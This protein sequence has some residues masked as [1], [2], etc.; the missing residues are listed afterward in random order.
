MAFALSF[1]DNVRGAAFGAR[2]LAVALKL[3]EPRRV[4]CALAFQ[5]GYVGSAGTQVWP[6]T[7]RL[8]T[9]ATELAAATGD[10]YTIALVEMATGVAHFLCGRYPEVRPHLERARHIFV[11]QCTGVAWEID[12]TQM[13]A[14]QCCIVFGEFREVSRVHP[15]YLREATERGDAYAVAYLCTGVSGIHW[16]ARDEP[17]RARE[18]AREAMKN[19][20]SHGFHLE[21]FYEQNLLGWIELYEGRTDDAERRSRALWPAVKRSLLSRVQMVRILAI[22][23][24]LI[25]SLAVAEGDP[26]CKSTALR[27][28]SADC[29]R[30]AR[31]GSEYASAALFRSCIVSVTGEPSER[32]ALAAR[33]AK[34][35]LTAV[36]C[37]A[38]AIFAQRLLGLAMG[39][40]EGRAVVA[41]AEQW[42]LDQ[43]VRDPARFSRCFARGF[44]RFESPEPATPAS[45]ALSPHPPS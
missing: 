24:R 32:V 12:T 16:L 26:R 14:L 25:G 27:S 2:N 13:L 43:G 20:S 4:A 37:T 21:H 42:L 38:H 5:L 9:R 29:A 28:A 41:S 7:Q 8:I 23:Q 30:L 45:T 35:A 22:E 31:E 17:D 36:G 11:S 1:A 6:Q 34:N 3:G 10:P 33:A 40:D 44:A 15:Q 39:G 18:H 19:W